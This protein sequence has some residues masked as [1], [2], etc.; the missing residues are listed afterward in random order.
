MFKIEKKFEYN[1]VLLFKKNNFDFICI[2]FI[3]NFKNCIFLSLA[4]NFNSLKYM[5]KEY[6]FIYLFIDSANIYSMLPDI[7]IVKY[8]T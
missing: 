7:I 3:N 2:W 1:S 6:T 8:A 4:K 5:K